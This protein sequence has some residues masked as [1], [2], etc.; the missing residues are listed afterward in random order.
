MN[1]K[2]ALPK[3]TVRLYWQAGLTKAEISRRVKSRAAG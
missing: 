1:P 2:T 3:G